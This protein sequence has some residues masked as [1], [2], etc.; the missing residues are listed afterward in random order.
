M[1]TEISVEDAPEIKSVPL[2]VFLNALDQVRI[3]RGSSGKDGCWCY[4]CD[5]THPL[6]KHTP[7]CRRV[8]QLYYDH[9]GQPPYDGFGSAE[10][11]N[12]DLWTAVLA[13]E[14]E[15]PSADASEEG[16]PKHPTDRSVV[17]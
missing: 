14:L 4:A 2:A 9:G 13:K 1:T 17:I 6:D 11:D 7:T 3:G 15:E 12:A 8:A 5:P 16:E 10:A